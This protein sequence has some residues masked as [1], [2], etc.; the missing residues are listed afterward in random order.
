MKKQTRQTKSSLKSSVLVLL[1]VAIL[2]IS[3]SYAWFTANQTVAISSIT[4]NVEASNG[5]QIST[6][7]TTWKSIITNEDITNA[8]SNYAAAVNQF[9][10]TIAPCSSAGTVTNGRLNIYYG[11]VSTDS[12]GN[13]IVQSIKQTDANGTSGYYV[14]FDFFL[15]VN[16]STPIYITTTSQMVAA[17]STDVGLQNAARIAFINEGNS[18]GSVATIQALN[19]GTASILWEPNYDV[20]TAKAVQAASDYYGITTSTTGASDL[21]PYNAFNSEFSNQALIQRSGGTPSGFASTT[22]QIRTVKNFTTQPSFTTLSDGVTKFR[23][24]LWIEGQDVDCENGA[25]GTD[26]TFN[27]G[28]TMNA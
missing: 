25:S 12:G 4:V 22:P 8:S 9:P 10:A 21:V 7:A 24:Y 15:K 19:G 23:C 20:H 17:G 28:F 16:I 27:I 14:A 26:M 18:D 3:S 2:L 6:D 13:F 5:I 11:D 1:L